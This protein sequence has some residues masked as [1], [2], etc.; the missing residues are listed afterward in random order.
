MKILALEFS[1]RHR[2]VGITEGAQALSRVETDEVRQSPLTLIDRAL[3]EANLPRESI[4]TI[5]LGT[6]PGSYTGIRSAIATAQGWQLARN[7]NL[8]PIP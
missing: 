6:G 2:S 3:N 4:S 7:I 8:L 1:S 5:A